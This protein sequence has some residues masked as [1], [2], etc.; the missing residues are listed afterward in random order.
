MKDFLQD[1]DHDRDVHDLDGLHSPDDR[2]L[3]RLGSMHARQRPAP[4]QL[5]QVG[6][7][8]MLSKLSILSWNRV[9]GQE[10]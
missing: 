3:Y 2:R 9:V 1:S 5:E 10:E 6:N 8:H 4:S 7:E